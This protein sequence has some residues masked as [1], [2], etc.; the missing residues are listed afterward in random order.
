MKSSS[1]VLFA[2]A[3][4]LG[5]KFLLAADSH[6][7]GHALANSLKGHCT[8]KQLSKRQPK[9]SAPPERG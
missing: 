8:N 2:A 6:A 4:F 1:N 3:G 5:E 9:P 7:G